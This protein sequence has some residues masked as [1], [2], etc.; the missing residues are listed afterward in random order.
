[1]TQMLTQNSP[2]LMGVIS[3]RLCMRHAAKQDQAAETKMEDEPALSLLYDNDFCLLEPHQVHKKSSPNHKRRQ[4]P[5]LVRE[6]AILVDGRVALCVARTH[7][8]ELFKNALLK[9]YVTHPKDWDIA[10]GITMSNGFVHPLCFPFKA[11]SIIVSMLPALSFGTDCASAVPW[12]VYA[13]ADAVEHVLEVPSHMDHVAF[14]LR[15][16]ARHRTRIDYALFLHTK[17]LLFGQATLHPA[18]P[19]M[20]FFFARML[21]CKELLQHKL[22]CL[23]PGA[24]TP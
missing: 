5:V 4:Q 23:N 13:P 6:R 10:Q 12:T 1:M 19:P 21:S 14:L 22:L 9:I 11:R 15:Y 8:P 3:K 16:A 24:S 18:S 7:S 20:T 17:P 2:V